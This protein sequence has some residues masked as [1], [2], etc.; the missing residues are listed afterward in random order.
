MLA[1]SVQH[2]EYKRT[3]V[4]L[5]LTINA[6]MLPYKICNLKSTASSYPSRTH[7]HKA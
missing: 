4:V 2:S 7:Q 3:K 6:C 5:F 1:Y